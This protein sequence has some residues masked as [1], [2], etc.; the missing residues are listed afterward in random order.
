MTVTRIR[1]RQ[2]PAHHLING[3][4]FSMPLLLAVWV[5]GYSITLPF[6][7]DD[8]PHVQI[9]AQTNGIQHWGDFPPFPFYRPFTFTLWKLFDIVAGEYSAPMLHLLN[10][11]CFGLAGVVLGQLLRRMLPPHFSRIAALLSGCLF[12]LFP[13]SY[14]AVAMVA[15]FFHLTLTLGM[16]LCLWAASVWLSGRGGYPM[17]VLCWVAAFCS[18]FSHENGVLLLPLLVGFV[19]MRHSIT[20]GFADRVG[21]QRA[22]PLLALVIL[23][24]MLIVL[25]YSVLWLSFRPQET[26]DLNT[27]LDVSLAVLLQGLVY[28]FAALLRPL[29]ESDVEP[30]VLLALVAVVVAAVIGWVY[31]RS[32]RAAEGMAR[33]APTD[34]PFTVMLFG[35]GWYVLAVLPAAV[36]LPAGYVL[37]QPRL[38]LLASVGGSMFWSVALAYLTNHTGVIGAHCCAPLRGTMRFFLIVVV[39]ALFVYV[40]LEFLAMRRDDFLRLRDFNR[41]AVALL[42]AHNADEIGAVLVN[43][44]DY[45]IPDRSDRRFLL[46]TEGVLFVD[47]TLDYNQQF[48]MNS[49]TFY[50][51]IDV[52]AYDQIQRNTGY[53]FRAHPPALG[54]ADVGERV[55]SVPLVIVTRFEDNGAFVPVLVGGTTLQG[56]DTPEVLYPEI[57]FALTSA[58]ARYNRDTGM[59]KTE[60]RWQVEE[61]AGVKMFVHVYCGE[62]F[63][64]QS[65][66]YPWGDTYP[67]TMWAP[68]EIQTDIRYIRLP[69]TVTP[70]CLRVQTGLYREA[71]VSRLRAVSAVDGSRYPDDVYPVTVEVEKAHSG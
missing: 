2:K 62:E 56:D 33:H 5:Y 43:V 4:L 17:L 51:N 35:L 71:D 53:G 26:T 8:G 27:A 41:R 42:D 9:L 69:D 40:S 23:P 48:W 30:L 67:F 60:V 19:C 64:S 13:F 54:P 36:L 14:Q 37:G 45:L 20:L 58:A 7:L 61:P 12:V 34:Q 65:D 47:E 25:A 29:V 28:P 44:P 38:A 52:I 66:G 24:V 31:W 6:F 39:I 59:L 63:V 10:V 55:R 15:A 50:Q 3:V 57:D 32:R 49:D 21:A 18:V 11:L 1:Q 46:G 22:A 16:L 70:D 68:G